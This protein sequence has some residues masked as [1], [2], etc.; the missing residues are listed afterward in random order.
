[1]GVP[2]H[3]FTQARPAS[4]IQHCCHCRDCSDCLDCPEMP[5]TRCLNTRFC[6]R[7]QRRPLLR[8]PALLVVRLGV[9]G[10]EATGRRLG[11]RGC[12]AIVFLR[13]TGLGWVPVRLVRP[14]IASFNFLCVD[15]LLSLSRYWRLMFASRSSGVSIMR[16]S[17]MCHGPS[18]SSGPKKRPRSTGP[19]LRANWT[20]VP[21]AGRLP[22]LKVKF[23]F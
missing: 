1:V 12:V 13:A 2:Q 6:F 7:F 17:A 3:P 10:L 5:P 19:L 8:G 23:E 14:M 15:C 21:P 20:V 4:P 11:R 9:A 16:L 22:I 18:V